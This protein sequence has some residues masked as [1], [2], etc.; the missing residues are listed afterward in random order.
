MRKPMIPRPKPTPALRA[1]DHWVN[2]SLRWG[3]LNRLY[4]S[5]PPSRPHRFQLLS[6]LRCRRNPGDHAQPIRHPQKS[7]ATFAF[8]STGQQIKRPGGDPCDVFLRRFNID[9]WHHKHFALSC[10]KHCGHGT[11]LYRRKLNRCSDFSRNLSNELGIF[12]SPRIAGATAMD[13]I[14]QAGFDP[15]ADR[16]SCREASIRSRCT[17]RR[18]PGNPCQQQLGSRYHE[19][20]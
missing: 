17:A 20:A 14:L 13:A 5:S 2:G 8:I 6:L 18:S 7:P 16:R 15:L 4:G 11:Y 3:G 10:C 19:L 1:I 12:G 9:R